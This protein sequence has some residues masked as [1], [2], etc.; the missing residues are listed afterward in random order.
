MPQESIR[1]LVIVGDRNSQSLREDSDLG[2]LCKDWTES[3]NSHILPVAQEGTD[4]NNWLPQFISRLNASFWSKNDLF[5]AVA[6]ILYVA[7][8]DPCRRVF[9]SYKRTECTALSEQLFVA[10]SKERCDVFLDRFCVPPAWDFQ[11]KLREDLADKSLVLVLESPT[12]MDSKWVQ[13]ELNF[14]KINKIGILAI[15]PPNLASKRQIAGIQSA[16]RIELCSCEYV[17]SQLTEQGLRK[18]IRR[19]LKESRIAYLK[20][21]FELKS[22]LKFGL[23]THGI[24]AKHDPSGIVLAQSSS[25]RSWYGLWATPMLPKSFDFYKAS[26]SL[27]RC[28]K[29]RCIVSPAHAH[30]GQ[31]RHS[32]T[33][34][35]SR[36]TRIRLYT[37]SQIRD[38]AFKIQG[39]KVL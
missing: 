31:D 19:V 13:Y 26:E 24:L 27:S 37:P 32:V 35:L 11:E 6:D 22:G 36:M 7:G 8:L 28:V 5:E 17:N 1:V 38:L 30:A 18:I 39:G 2:G 21:L 16:S 29:H 9:I 34:W 14:A 23:Q 20:R 4:I 12:L 33:Q 3:E 25:G 10:L 15:K